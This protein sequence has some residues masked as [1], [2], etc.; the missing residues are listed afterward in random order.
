[1]RIILFAAL[2]CLLSACASLSERAAAR[3][4]DNGLAGTRWGL[5]VVTTEGHEIVSVNP[6][7][8]FLPASNTKIF[9]VAAAFHRL[10][11]LWIPDPASGASVRLVPGRDGAPPD[12]MIVG[13]GDAMLT[14]TPDCMRDC[15]SDLADMLVASRVRLVNDITGDDRLFPHQPWADGWSWE[16]LVT[17]SGAAVSALT[18]NS[19]ERTLLV[20]PGPEAGQVA[21]LE[22]RAADAPDNENSFIQNDLVTRAPGEGVSDMYFAERLPDTG[23][24]RLYGQIVQGGA[25]RTLAVATARPAEDAALRF[26]RL[27]EERGIKVIGEVRAVHRPIAASDHPVLRPDHPPARLDYAGTEIGRLVPPPLSEDLTVIMKQSQNLHAEILLRRLGL[28]KGTGSIEDGLAVVGAMLAEAG[29]PRWA[30]DLSDGAGMSIYNR[31]TPR[32]VANFLLWTL[33]QPWG[34]AFRD[35]LPVGGVDGTLMRRF[36]G[37]PLEGRI[38][39]KTGTL[40]GTNALSGFLIA[41]S[42]RMLIFSAYANERPSVAPGALDALEATLVE[43]AEKT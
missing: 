19:N 34:G 37:T 42:G 8:R 1:M 9:T 38:F 28:L 43:I 39:A 32:L 10:G 7:Q 11:D 40:S 20:T 6:D 31:V 30:W 3:L 21:R 25:P 36:K 12:V 17:R 5:V 24:L 29:A 26:R 35:T 22:W 16:D 2:T 18:V 33:Q 27:L 23:T 15:L 14:D 41:R 13:G 4:A